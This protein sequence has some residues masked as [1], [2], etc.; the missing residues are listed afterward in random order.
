MPL[1]L[2]KVDVPL[3]EELRSPL[4]LAEAGEGFPVGRVDHTVL[5]HR[6]FP[7]LSGTTGFMFC[8][9]QNHFEDWCKKPSVA[10][11][12]TYPCEIR[13]F[14]GRGRGA[15][16]DAAGHPLL[17]PGGGDLQQAV[18]VLPLLLVVLGRDVVET[19][20]EAA[21]EPRRRV[22]QVLLDAG[23]VVHAVAVPAHHNLAPS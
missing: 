17:E 19:A 3:Q 23:L 18:E 9:K 21:D 20:A 8:G 12:S 14:G 5:A 15:G 16:Q 11:F 4:L 6:G 7:V 2:V 10:N 1:Y 13:I 22:D